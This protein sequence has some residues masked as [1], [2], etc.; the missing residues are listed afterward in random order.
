M[1]MIPAVMTTLDVAELTGR[2]H[3]N[4]QRDLKNLHQKIGI[5][6]IEVAIPPEGDRERTTKGYSLDSH[7]ALTLMVATSHPF[8]HFVISNLRAFDSVKNSTD[9]KA[10]MRVLVSMAGAFIEAT[11][12]KE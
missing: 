9:F 7:T 11:E 5:P 2:K 1:K 10:V 6:L 12:E 3:W 8:T 4:V